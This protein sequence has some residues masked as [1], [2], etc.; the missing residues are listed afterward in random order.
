[1]LVFETVKDLVKVGDKFKEYTPI[2]QGNNAGPHQDA[3]FKKGA[4]EY[5]A[6]EGFKWIL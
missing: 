4:E 6:R 5:C 2:I 1:M 3:T